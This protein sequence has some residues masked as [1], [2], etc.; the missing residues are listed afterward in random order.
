MLSSHFI[1]GDMQT[2]QERGGQGVSP[3]PPAC[4]LWPLQPRLCLLARWGAGSLSQT[5]T[6]RIPRQC[7]EQPGGQLSLHSQLEHTLQ[8]KVAEVPGVCFAY[9]RGWEA[10]AYR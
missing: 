5:L 1:W 8:M 6:F 9:L 2:A 7:W 10:A 3:R 4:V